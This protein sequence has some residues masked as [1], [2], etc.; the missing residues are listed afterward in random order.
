LI[1]AL[2][3]ANRER[4][5]RLLRRAGGDVALIILE[6]SCEILEVRMVRIGYLDWNSGAAKEKQNAC[7]LLARERSL[8]LSLD[9]PARRIED[10]EIRLASWIEPQ[11]RG[12]ANYSRFKRD[13]QQS[14]L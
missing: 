4:D 6:V 10:N 9:G 13:L 8:P 12:A 3:W 11:L 7:W 1:G 2:L 14:S 5:D